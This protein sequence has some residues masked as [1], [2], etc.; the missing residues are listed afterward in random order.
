MKAAL[1][2]DDD[3]REDRVDRITLLTEKRKEYQEHVR[4]LENALH[5]LG[6]YQDEN[7]RFQNKPEIE[8]TKGYNQVVTIPIPQSGINIRGHLSFRGQQKAEEYFT[9]LDEDRDGYLTYE[10]FR[11]MTS[12][13]R[14]PHGIAHDDLYKDWDT[15]KMHMADA[16]V[17]PDFLGRI[18]QE[19]FVRYRIWQEKRPREIHL[20]P[21]IVRAGL[22]VLPATQL[23]WNDVKQMVEDVIID[24]EYQRLLQQEQ[25]GAREQLMNVLN[26]VKRDDGP[27]LPLK[28][29]MYD[30]ILELDEMEYIL[31]NLGVVYPRGM[32]AHLLRERAQ[33]LSILSLPLFKTTTI[34]Y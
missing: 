29:R 25:E 20:E 19:Q 5:G 26:K 10:D 16:G 12:L 8:I 31:V 1:Y 27:K 33:V 9:R 18:T 32:L 17:T 6:C 3:D 34:T 28:E 2:E 22:G 15:W 21:E 30:E 23:Y 14:Y 24:R 7:G 13:G 4:A 11:A